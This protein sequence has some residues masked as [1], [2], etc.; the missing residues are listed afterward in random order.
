VPGAIREP[1][2]SRL[3][4][5]ANRYLVWTGLASGVVGVV[6]VSLVSRRLLSRM[7][8]LGS[9]ARRLGSGDLP[10]RVATTGSTEHAD[11]AG[12]FNTMQ[13]FAERRGTVEELG[14]RC[15]LRV[16]NSSFQHSTIP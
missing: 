4:S 11:L 2:I 13:E 8:A 1:P 15:G 5:T 9:A 14:C 3:A 10:Q 6:M 12:S 16:E 7:Q